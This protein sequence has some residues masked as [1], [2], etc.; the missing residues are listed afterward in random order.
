MGTDRLVDPI[1]A[2]CPDDQAPGASRRLRNVA[3]IGLAATE[4]DP[5]PADLR[6]ATL[7]RHGCSTS[8]TCESQGVPSRLTTAINAPTAIEGTIT[9]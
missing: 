3:S 8:E 1:A 7:P 4:I 2:V 5:V 6:P 9:R